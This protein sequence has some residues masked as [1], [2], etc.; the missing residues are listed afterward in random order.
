M[1]ASNVLCEFLVNRCRPFI[2]ATAPSPLIA[3]AVTEALAMVRDEPQRRDRLMELVAF[4]NREIQIRCG[5]EPSGS[6]IIPI[7]IGNNS[8]VMAIAAILRA[9]GF[10]LRGFCPPSVPDDMG[11]IRISL[12][13]NVDQADVSA[14][15][16]AL[17]E[18]LESGPV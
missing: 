10:D 8:R 6:Q 14:M 16:E 2:Y 4:T 5:I 1:T 18:E 13:I 11:H 12:T 17:V 15:I 9:R 3:V 7:N